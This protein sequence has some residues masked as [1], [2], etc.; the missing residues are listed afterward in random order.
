MDQSRWGQDW[1]DAYLE[2]MT[3]DDGLLAGPVAL[4]SSDADA[5][6]DDGEYFTSVYLEWMDNLLAAGGQVRETV[7]LDA[8]HIEAECVHILRQVL[9]YGSRSPEVLAL[10]LESLRAANDL[11]ADESRAWRVLT[12]KR[13]WHMSRTPAGAWEN[14]LEYDWSHALEDVAVDVQQLTGR[15]IELQSRQLSA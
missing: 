12:A 3:G 1:I 4:A 10:T 5:D 8:L 6:M 13:D 9:D 7:L 11:L 2:W 14:Q 15:V